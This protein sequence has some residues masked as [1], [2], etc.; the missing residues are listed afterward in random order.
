MT[1]VNDWDTETSVDYYILDSGELG[2][3]VFDSWTGPVR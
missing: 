1:E 2:R 3:V